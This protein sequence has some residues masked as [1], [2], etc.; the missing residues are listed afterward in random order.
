[1][2]REW[3]GRGWVSKLHAFVDS[4]R[5]LTC[6]LHIVYAYLPTSNALCP[7]PSN[8]TDTTASSSS[9]ISSNSTDIICNSD[10]GT[11]LGRGKFAFS[12][13]SYTSIMMY[14]ALNTAPNVKDGIVQ[15]WAGNVQVVNMTDLIL[16]G[17]DVSHS[18]GTNSMK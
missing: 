9:I 8:T 12:R 4:S 7:G 1:V 18:K 14:V 17:E 3:N 15:I 13:G 11:S 16:T 10:Y 2:E 6:F 5:S